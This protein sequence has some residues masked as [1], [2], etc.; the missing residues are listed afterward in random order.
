MKLAG[1]ATLGPGFVP[2]NLQ[3]DVDGDVSARLLAFVAP[4]AVS[5]AQ[6]KAHVR[7]H[8]RGT[9]LKPEIRGRLDLDTIDFRLRDLGTEVQVQSGIVEISNDGV[10]LHNVRVLLDDQGMLVIGASGVR[11]GP[12]PVHEP[13][14]LQARRVRPAA[15]RRAAHLPQPRRRSRSTTWPSTS[16]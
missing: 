4:D 9:L 12:R 5:D 15:A 3:A 16:I 8:L 13:R 10:V 6:G 14:P 11:A 7:A 1:R 2:E